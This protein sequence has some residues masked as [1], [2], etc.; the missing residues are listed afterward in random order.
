MFGSEREAL[1]IPLREETGKQLLSAYW[2][3]TRQNKRVNRVG[4]DFNSL[5]FRN[6]FLRE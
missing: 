2:E 3:L 5:S 1:G 4:G 6:H